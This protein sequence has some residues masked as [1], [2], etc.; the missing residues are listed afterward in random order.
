MN[1]HLFKELILARSIHGPGFLRKFLLINTLLLERCLTS[2]KFKAKV[3]LEQGMTLFI[4]HIR[5]IF[6]KI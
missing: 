4:L 5:K 2:R 1:E 6:N 3:F